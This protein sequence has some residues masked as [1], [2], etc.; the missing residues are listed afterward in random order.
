MIQCISVKHA[1]ATYFRKLSGQILAE[2][3]MLKRP[4]L[5]TTE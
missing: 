2:A 4:M 1:I 3:E 5:I